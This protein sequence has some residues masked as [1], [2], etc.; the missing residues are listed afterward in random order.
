[1]SFTLVDKDTNEE[2][3]VSNPETG[4]INFPLISG[5]KYSFVIHTS[6]ACGGYKI[7][8]KKTL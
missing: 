3:V 8:I 7:R 1:M 6:N 2:K 4:I 5:H